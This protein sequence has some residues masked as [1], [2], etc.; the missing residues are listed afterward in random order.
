MILLLVAGHT[1]WDLVEARRLLRLLGVLTTESSLAAQSRVQPSS[2][3]WEP[4]F[5]E[6]A[7]LYLA[8]GTLARYGSRDTARS[9]INQLL[10]E[11]GA[12]LPAEALGRIRE[13]LDRQSEALHLLD[14][15]TSLQFTR[16]PP[17]ARADWGELRSLE[18]LCR[19]RSAY[20]ALIGDGEAASASIVAELML[21]G[22]PSRPMTPLW[23][24]LLARHTETTRN[25]QRLLRRTGPSEA[26]LARLAAALQE[27]DDDA[28]WARYFARDRDQQFDPDRMPW[29]YAAASGQVGLLS[30]GGPSWFKLWRPLSAREVRRQLERYEQLLAASRTPWPDRIDRVLDV[31]GPARSTVAQAYGRFLRLGTGWIADPD[32]EQQ[33]RQLQATALDLAG[34]RAA[35]VAVAIERYRRA[36]AKELPSTL[37]ALVP[38]YLDAVPIDPFS[39]TPVRLRVEQTEFVVYSVGID[40][41]DADGEEAEAPLG[42]PGTTG[43]DLRI[44]GDVGIRLP[45]TRSDR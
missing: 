27:A 26:A 25:V 4:A 17:G 16:F 6:A 32:P 18:W 44:T 12:D 19:V 8:A 29:A 13:F 30:A 28:E 2:P 15:A 34:L 5:G 43:W 41:K 23:P 22:G 40:Q 33:R 31:T 42:K 11:D 35:R 38:A 24:F 14:R 39:G 21:D 20:A 7:P 36:H 45:I 9:Q 10:H 37:Q 3:P 1:A